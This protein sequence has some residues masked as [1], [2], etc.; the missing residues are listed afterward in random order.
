[1][2]EK[3]YP[4]GHFEIG[5]SLNSIGAFYEDQNMR[6]EALEYYQRALIIFEK[7]LPVEDSRRVGTMRN[8]VRLAE[9]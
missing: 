4:A 1:M 7:F 6:E 9:Q 5:V 2:Q 8:I 3:Y